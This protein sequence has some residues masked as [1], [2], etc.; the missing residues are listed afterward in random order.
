MLYKICVKFEVIW[1]LFSG[2]TFGFNISAVHT[3]M[4]F[5]QLTMS[6]EINCHSSAKWKDFEL[7]SSD[8]V[9]SGA[10]RIYV[11][12][13][14]TFFLQEHGQEPLISYKYSQTE[15]S[16]CCLICLTEMAVVA[17]I[18]MLQVWFA[19]LKKANNIGY[20]LRY[21]PGL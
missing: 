9:C 8:Q 17:L 7:K 1:S 3:G 16:H 15:N 21:D 14:M 5:C 13:K 4:A 20:L 10:P 12:S 6:F 19:P 11:L 18:Q 2:S